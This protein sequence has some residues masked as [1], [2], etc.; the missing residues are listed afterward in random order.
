MLAR[1]YEDAARPGEDWRFMCGWNMD[2][3]KTGLEMRY[4]RVRG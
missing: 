2:A 3:R 1:A 4:C